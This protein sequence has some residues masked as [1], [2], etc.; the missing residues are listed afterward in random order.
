MCKVYCSN[1]DV[2]RS[3]AFFSGSLEDCVQVALNL[4]RGSNLPHRICVF[5]ADFNEVLTFISKDN[6]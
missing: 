3:Y 6:G 2:E 1:P 4:H 5:D